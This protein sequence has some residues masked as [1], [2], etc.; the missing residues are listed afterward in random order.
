MSFAVSLENGALEYAGTEKPHLLFAQTRNLLRPRFWRMLQDLLRFY[1]IAPDDLAW[2]EREGISLG[3]Y[4]NHRGY[5]DSFIE[6]HLLPMTAAIWSTPS[7]EARDYPAAAFIRFCM[8]HGLLRI[9]DRPLWRTV[10]GGSRVYV[11]RLTAR[12]ADRL[13]PRRGVV[14]VCRDARGVELRDRLAR[15]GGSTMW[16]SRRMRTPRC[17]CWRIPPMPKPCCSGRSATV[18]IMP[19]C[20]AMRA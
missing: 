11:D 17:R 19:C 2:L 10:D 1:R 18:T 14:S 20:I 5:R 6:D 7:A 13:R 16:S 12:F 15:L 8:N 9:T 3:T 4:L